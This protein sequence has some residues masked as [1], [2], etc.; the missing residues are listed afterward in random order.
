MKA[1]SAPN[2]SDPNGNNEF[3]FR[4]SRE[5]L[6]IL[7]DRSLEQAKL[8]KFWMFQ[9]KRQ[10]DKNA[11]YLDVLL[12]HDLIDQAKADEVRQSSDLIQLDL[13]QENLVELDLSKKSAE[14]ADM[15]LLKLHF[16][17]TWTF[18]YFY[19]AD[20]KLIKNIVKLRF[21]FAAPLFY[22][23]LKA[24]YRRPETIRSLVSGKFKKKREELDQHYEQDSTGIRA[25]PFV[26]P[27]KAG[28][29]GRLVVNWQLVNDVIQRTKD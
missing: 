17:H 22:E 12:Q 26:C 24:L 13:S 21:D 8:T 23:E 19:C 2:V 5:Y 10:K 3:P 15:D 18:Y 11:E 16:F 27:L 20:G 6:G 4:N 7:F 1:S 29:D 9:E 25:Y 14:Q 28:K